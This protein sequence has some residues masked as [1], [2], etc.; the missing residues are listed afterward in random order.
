MSILFILI[1]ILLL[2]S[3]YVHSVRLK[4]KKVL[5]PK[6]HRLIAKGQFSELHIATLSDTQHIIKLFD[7]SQNGKTLW[8]KANNL[9]SY[10]VFAKSN[11]LQYQSSHEE[12][13][14]AGNIVYCLVGRSTSI[15]C[16][17]HTYLQ[18]NI[19]TFS[20]FSSLSMSAVSGLAYLHMYMVK[21]SVTK[22]SIVHRYINSDN[23]LVRADMNCVLCNFEYALP[24]TGRKTPDGSNELVC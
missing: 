3:F 10:L 18:G 17:L 12:C 23:F 8:E 1:I 7:N 11:V 20:E 6:F 9:Q 15:V 24:L 4:Y 14:Y 19:I 13:L 16:S 2:L 5:K 22:H 21:S